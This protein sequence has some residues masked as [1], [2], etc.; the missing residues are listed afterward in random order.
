MGLQLAQRDV[1]VIYGGCRTG[2]M[3]VLAESY[4]AGG[5]TSITGVIPRGLIQFSSPLLTEVH[6]TDTIHQRKRMMLDLSDGFVT[7]PGGLGTL[8]ELLEVLDLGRI[9]AHEKPIGI[10]NVDNYFDPF[11]TLLQHVR[12]TG[13]V[14]HLT[15]SRPIVDDI[16]ERLLDTLI[17]RIPST[18]SEIIIPKTAG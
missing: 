4:V 8:D 11:M 2:L 10:L 7:L 17:D 5:G 14:F 9:G 12:D 3:G 1:A 16:C 6:V 15:F 18:T 13:F